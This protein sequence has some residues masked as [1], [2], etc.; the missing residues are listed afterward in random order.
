MTDELSRTRVLEAG[1]SRF[2][3]KPFT[4]E[5]ILDEVRGLLAAGAS[6]QRGAAPGERG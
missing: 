2:M 1:A 5:T 3:V 6:S 4:P